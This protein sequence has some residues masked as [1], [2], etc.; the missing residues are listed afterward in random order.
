MT[1]SSRSTTEREPLDNPD[2]L[3]P[4]EELDL[5]ILEWI[6]TLARPQTPPQLAGG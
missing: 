1:E 4:P 5:A 6:E 2:H 3:E